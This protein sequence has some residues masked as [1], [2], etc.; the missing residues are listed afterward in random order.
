VQ[1]ERL[2]AGQPQGITVDADFLP[3][4]IDPDSEFHHGL[5]IH[6]HATGRDQ[7]LALPATAK[8][9]E[10]QELLKPYLG[11]CRPFP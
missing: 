5:P 4:R 1:Q 10:G 6:L 8:S 9:R 2:L 3:V 11:I 7:F